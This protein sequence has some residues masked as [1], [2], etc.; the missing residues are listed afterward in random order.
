MRRSDTRG[1]GRRLRPLPALLTLALAL[2]V[3]APALVAC[4]S[5]GVTASTPVTSGRSQSS[6]PAAATT[7]TAPPSA[8]TSSA[9]AVVRS[10]GISAL[11]DGAAK[12]GLSVSAVNLDTGVSLTMGARSGMVDAS[13]SKVMLIEILVLKRQQAGKKLSSYERSLATRM[14][15]NSDNNAASAIFNLIGGHDEVREWMPKVG[16][17]KIT[18]LGPDGM[19]GLTRSSAAEQITLL[20]NLTDTD[21]P[22]TK[23]NRAYIL[24]LMRNVEA[25]QRWG[26]GAAADDDDFANKNGWDTESADKG[27]WVTNSDGVIEVDGHRVIMSVMSQH[28]TSLSAGV[29]L[30][31]K[32]AV[33]AAKAVTG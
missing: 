9:P 24:T 5:S 10:T 27:R 6:T 29:A 28:N 33:D 7:S 13:V 2:A 26:V 14:I 15:E 21:S 25:D 22:L 20:H 8:A 19:W 31:E 12:G 3:V 16:L 17:T 11:I 30:I 1:T 32:V 4:H 23:A 18:V